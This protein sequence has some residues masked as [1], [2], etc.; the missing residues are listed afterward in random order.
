M[1]NQSFDAGT[2]PIID[3]LYLDRELS[4]H[5]QRAT[6]KTI[7]L[8]DTRKRKEHCISRRARYLFIDT[9]LP[10]P[11]PQ[12]LSSLAFLSS[13]VNGVIRNSPYH[14]LTLVPTSLVPT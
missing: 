11:A 9:S 7:V 2:L 10:S 4:P 3:T 6:R 1:L 12:P 5:T 8:S 13:P 14:H